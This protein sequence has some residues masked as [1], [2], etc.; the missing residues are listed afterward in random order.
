MHKR[1]NRRAQ[2][3]AN[4]GRPEGPCLEWKRTAEGEQQQ[5]FIGGVLYAKIDPEGEA[6][7]DYD[8][9]GRPQHLQDWRAETES[10]KVKVFPDIDAARLW[11]ERE[12]AP[13]S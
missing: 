7:F 6:R 4:Q 13:A 8:D 11:C 12:Y 3:L 5:L 2:Y 9:V 10:G 1:D